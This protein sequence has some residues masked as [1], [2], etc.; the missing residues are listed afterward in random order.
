MNDS[1]PEV[2]FE[3]CKLFKISY[4]QTIRKAKSFFIDEILVWECPFC[5]SYGTIKIEILYHHILRKT[6]FAYQCS[7]CK[8]PCM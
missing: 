5:K 3:Y 8:N 1:K 4:Q 6:I 2:A 7:K